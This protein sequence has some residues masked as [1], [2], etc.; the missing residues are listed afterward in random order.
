[1]KEPRLM[2]SALKEKA[3]PFC[4]KCGSE[5][6]DNMDFCPKCGTRQEK[7]SSA[8]SSS[9][10]P[11]KTPPAPGIAVCPG[12]GKQYQVTAEHFKGRPQFQFK[13]TGCQGTVTAVNPNFASERQKAVPPSTAGAVKATPTGINNPQ[14]SRMPSNEPPAKAAPTP[15]PSNVAFPPGTTTQA[16]L[17]AGGASKT[18]KK[19]KNKLLWVLGGLMSFCVLSFVLVMV[20]QFLQRI[21]LLHSGFGYE[22]QGDQ[23]IASY[24][25]PNGYEGSG[26]YVCLSDDV[27]GT[28][29]DVSR[30]HPEVKTLRIHFFKSANG[31][32]DKYGNALKDDVDLGWDEF[33]TDPEAKNYK[34]VESFKFKNREGIE[35]HLRNNGRLTYYMQ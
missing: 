13:C 15:Q 1:M 25:I 11:P 12:C 8:R 20:F 22:V 14:P 34:D 6:E 33:Q 16:S 7:S 26:A 28:L 18:P 31:L 23:A 30:R 2:P 17:K 10:A 35:Y 3:M 19:P 4:F 5:V 21:G 27:C 29:F 32:I 9:S 24:V